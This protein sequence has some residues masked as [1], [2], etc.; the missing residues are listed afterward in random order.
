MESFKG[1]NHDGGRVCYA[2][3]KECGVVTKMSVTGFAL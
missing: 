1:S 3:Y 2:C